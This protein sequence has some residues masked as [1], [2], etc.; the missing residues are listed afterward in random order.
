[1]E[2]EDLSF[3]NWK[4]QLRRSLWSLSAPLMPRRALTAKLFGAERSRELRKACRG[5]I[6]KNPGKARAGYLEFKGT[7]SSHSSKGR[8]TADFAAVVRNRRN[9]SFRTGTRQLNMIGNAGLVEPWSHG[10]APSGVH[11]S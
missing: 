4:S 7:G 11:E 10:A 6:E 2:V 1:M 8:V 3:A 5:R 9:G